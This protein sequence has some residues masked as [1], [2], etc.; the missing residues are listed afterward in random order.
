[1]QRTDASPPGGSAPP[2]WP[3]QIRPA[4][5][6][7]HI[8]MLIVRPAAAAMAG[9]SLYVVARHYGVPWQLAAAAVA[10]FDGVALGALYQATEAVKAGRSAATA[11]LATLGMAS[12]SLL[13]NVQHAR[14]IHGGVPAGLLFAT[15]A[16]GLLV[17][18]ALSWGATRAEARA[19]RGET[20]MRLPAFGLWGWLLAH[21]EAAGALQQR[22]REHVTSG[23]SPAHQLP[24]PGPKPSAAQ[25]R[26]KLTAR[27]AAMDVG[28]V[29]E[30]TAAS[31]PDM[32]PEEIAALLPTYGVHVDVLDVVLVLGRA[33]V[34]SVRLDRVPAAEPAAPA[35]TLTRGEAPAD[36]PQVSGLPL[37]EAIPAIHRR[38][39]DDVSAKAVVKC[40]ALQGMATDTGYVR[41]AL[42]R[43][44]LRAHEE[45][46]EEDARLA[47][48]ARSAERS[49]GTG[50][51]P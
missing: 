20:P 37:S 43:A 30:L 14:I 35:K 51:Y 13:L 34:P 42:S 16:V 29:I 2:T 26:T 33:A 36:M 31:H 1:M 41:T 5:I 28:E 24:A 38:L 4:R 23:A 27:F 17:L 32:T 22:A 18:S 48:A 10:V 39:V 25:A 3:F 46:A 44:R 15:P 11:I 21:N 6:A 12:V 8:A 40:L 49:S 9:W 45:A 47:A 19:A 7:W 50:F